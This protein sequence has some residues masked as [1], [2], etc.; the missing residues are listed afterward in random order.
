MTSLP[1]SLERMVGVIFVSSVFLLQR[2]H[3]HMGQTLTEQALLRNERR[4]IE[5]RSVLSQDAVFLAT[6]S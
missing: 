6:T 5:I 2:K 1:H 3:H 4:L